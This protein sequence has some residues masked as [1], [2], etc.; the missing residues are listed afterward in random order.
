MIPSPSLSPPPPVVDTGGAAKVGVAGDETRRDWVW[1]GWRET[2]LG[3]T[4]G[5]GGH[6]GADVE[7]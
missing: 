3:E 2:I 5:I 1:G 7:T 4:A 6:L